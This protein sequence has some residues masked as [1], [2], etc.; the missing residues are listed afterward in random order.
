MTQQDL[1][2]EVKLFDV[3][4]VSIRVIRA[5]LDGG[6]LSSVIQGGGN[7]AGNIGAARLN[8]RIADSTKHMAGTV[9]HLYGGKKTAGRI[10]IGDRDGANR[11]RV[12]DGHGGDH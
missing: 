1:T 2:P 3:S 8:P 5:V 10:K 4:R 11:R 7:G 6:L 12:C 9:F